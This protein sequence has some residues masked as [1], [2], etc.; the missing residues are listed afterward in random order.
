[1]AR[2]CSLSCA[3]RAR[4]RHSHPAARIVADRSCSFA[5]KRKARIENEKIG[6]GLAA[7]QVFAIFADLFA[8]DPAQQIA[9][10]GER[11]DQ[12]DRRA[13]SCIPARPEACAHIAD[14]RERRACAGLDEV[15]VPALDRWIQALR[16]RSAIV[17]R[18]RALSDPAAR[19][20]ENLRYL[21]CRS[22]SM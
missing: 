3:L 13:R 22:L 4:R 9:A 16:D 1:M 21:R 15:I 8:L 14:A 10:L 7:E 19:A 5:A 11:R 20:S 6:I 12:R 2:N 17:P 18:A